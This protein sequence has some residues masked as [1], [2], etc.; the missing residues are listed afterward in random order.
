MKA[1]GGMM[2]Y[3]HIFLTS[4]RDEG[5]CSAS[6]HSC[7]ISSTNWIGSLVGRRTG[8][9]VVAKRKNP[10]TAGK[11]SI[12]RTNSPSFQTRPI[13]HAVGMPSCYDV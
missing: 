6:R 10:V 8:L 7:F 9:D 13:R 4:A 11:P 12:I 1:Y 3:F 2:V 5:E